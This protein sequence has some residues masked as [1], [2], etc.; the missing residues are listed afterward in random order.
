[1]NF[2]PFENDTMAP[3]TLAQRLVEQFQSLDISPISQ[4]SV[5]IPTPF[6]IMVTPAVIRPPVQHFRVPRSSSAPAPVTAIASKYSRKR[7]LAVPRRSI[8]GESRPKQQ[9]VEQRN[10]AA[11]ALKYFPIRPVH[12]AVVCPKPLRPETHQVFVECYVQP[13]GP[14]DRPSSYT[15]EDQEIINLRAFIFENKDVE[16]MVASITSSDIPHY[17]CHTCR[18]F[19]VL[20][21]NSTECKFCEYFRLKTFKIDFDFTAERSD[22]EITSLFGSVPAYKE[23]KEAFEKDPKNDYVKPCTMCGCY[24]RGKWNACKGCG[25][26]F[27]KPGVLLMS[28]VM[29]HVY[30][31]GCNVAGENVVGHDISRV[32]T[33][34]KATQDKD[35]VQAV[36]VPDCPDAEELRFELNDTPQDTRELELNLP[37]AVRFIAECKRGTIVHCQ[38]GASRSASVVLAYMMLVSPRTTLAAAYCSL[39]RYRNIININ[40]GFME[41]L[42]RFKCLIDRNS[43][44]FAIVEKQIKNM[45]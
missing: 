9:C 19:N 32:L 3:K 31:T 23:C 36:K 45:S 15:N 12:P 43:K 5:T 42:K 38:A 33:I 40:V 21:S 7:N 1:M 11:L 41:M 29:K 20:V 22:E 25:T 26:K 6:R 27:V 18:E 16:S 28:P 8:P 24:T 2:L 37:K 30:L 13:I 44:A 39:Y 10:T 4:S 35:Y 14:N 34:G 17:M